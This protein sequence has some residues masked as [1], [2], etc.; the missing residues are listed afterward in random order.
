MDLTVYPRW[1]K[2]VEMINK[3][4]YSKELENW[5]ASSFSYDKETGDIRQTIERRSPRGQVLS[6]MG[7][8]CPAKNDSGYRIVSTKFQGKNY[9]IRAHRLAYF[10]VTGTWP[11]VIDH[12]NGKRD[13]NRWC[14]IRNVSSSINGLNRRYSLGKNSHLPI[15]IYFLKKNGYDTYKSSITLK[16]KHYS[17]YRKNL[18]SAIAWRVEK[19]KQLGI[20]ELE[21]ARTSK[22][23]D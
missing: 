2:S 4:T 8:I 9:L 5:L 16:G 7:R 22:S 3:A 10:L 1:G 17:T 15:G 6:P 20:C 12:I 19:I 13:D 11:D 23:S 18:E 21:E 14:N